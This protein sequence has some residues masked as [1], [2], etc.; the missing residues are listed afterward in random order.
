MKSSLEMVPEGQE[1]EE[2]HAQLH[3]LCQAE[4][5]TTV[6]WLKKE[7]PNLPSGACPETR[8]ALQ[9]LCPVLSSIR[10]ARLLDLPEDS[11]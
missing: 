5:I 7:N 6:G 2:D 4:N 1:V 11:E 9:D 3:W 10:L 8:L